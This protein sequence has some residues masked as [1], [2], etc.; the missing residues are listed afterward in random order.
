MAT[1]VMIADQLY[2]IRKMSAMQQFHVSRRIA[3]IIPLLMPVLTRFLQQGKPAGDDLEMIAAALQPLADGLAA[4]SD[5]ESEYVI[6]TCLE[7][8][9][10]KQPTGWASIWSASAKRP[11][12]DDIDLG[13]MLQL[14]VRVIMDNLGPFISG[15]LTNL[16]SSPQDRE[17]PAGIS[18][19][20]KTG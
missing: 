5:A 6:A 3:P 14:V 16:S 15:L 19:V 8:V 4:M 11:M 9:Q 2:S 20:A 1:E 13:V 12:F 18:P 7:V 10:R 17:A